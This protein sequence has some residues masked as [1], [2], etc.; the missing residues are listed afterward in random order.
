[1]GGRGGRGGEKR[2]GGLKCV[3]GQEEAGGG[4]ECGMY[5]DEMLLM[6][7]VCGG[8]VGTCDSHE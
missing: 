1:M 7:V 3:R 4:G 5:G 8:R 6:L 2:E